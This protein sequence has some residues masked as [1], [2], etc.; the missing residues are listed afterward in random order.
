[1]DQPIYPNA[2]IT[3][4]IAQ[5]I[6]ERTAR[7]PLPQGN[8]LLLIPLCGAIGLWASAL[9]VIHVRDMTDLGLL[10][11]FP[12]S[13]YIALGLL[14]IG[15]CLVVQRPQTPVWLLACYMIAL[16]VIIHGTPHLLYGTLRYSWAW[17]HIGIVDYIQ[18]HGMVN[19]EIAALHV[20]HNWP[21]FFALNAV[22]TEVAGFDSALAYAGWA[23]AFFNLLTGSALLLVLTTFTSERRLI[24]FSLWIFFLS[25]WIGQDYF[26]PQAFSYFL[27]AHGLCLNK[28]LP[29]AAR[30]AH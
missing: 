15:F 9:P 20:Y 1:M 6:S 11:V 10:S 23:P 3:R 29:T 7:T 17:K 22:L 5:S 30:P 13:I 19:P 26:S 16:V 14:T 21:G 4:R 18:R 12:L 27:S 25:N 24:G 8:W 28:W 2:S